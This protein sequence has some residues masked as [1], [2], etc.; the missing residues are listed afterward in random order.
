MTS[1]V[2]TAITFAP[3][4]GFIE[5]SRKLRDLYGSSFILS[6]LSQA[7][8]EDAITHGHEVISPALISVTQGTPNQIVICGDFSEVS[9]RTALARAWQA[10]VDVCRIE[11]ERRL[12]ESKLPGHYTWRRAWDAWGNHT[13]E[14][15]WAQGGSISEVRDR[16]NQTKRARR[17]VGINWQG[18][19]STLSGIDAVAWYGM[20]E[21]MHP[22]TSAAEIQRQVSDYCQRLSKALPDSILDATEQLSVPELIKRVLLVKDEGFPAR[23]KA[24]LE[25]QR[26]PAIEPPA[27]FTEVN[28][29]EANRWTA[30]FQGDGDR[31]GQFL[32]SSGGE[33]PVRLNAF[34][35]AMREWGKTFQTGFDQTQ[36]RIIYA[37]G[38]DFLG[39]LY[40]NPP[41]PELS[42]TEVLDYFRTFPSVWERHNQRDADG[43]LLTVSVGLV[44]AAPGVPQRDV[45]QHCREAE[46]AAKQ[47]G[48]DRLCIRVVFNGGNYLEWACP[49]WLLEAGL[50]E[51][52]RDRRGATKT[53]ASWDHL[54]ADVAALEARHGFSG[55]TNVALGLFEIYF[56]PSL[57]ALVEA[58][59]WTVGTQPGI[60]GDKEIDP[61]PTQNRL[62]QWVVNLAKV[63]YHL[64]RQPR[65]AARP[66]AA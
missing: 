39:I 49:W 46:Q 41:E 51:A 33:D 60:L 48:R 42:G 38:D 7:L 43:N 30:W 53:A 6:F 24:T 26:L 1:P 8:C 20:A 25:Q 40:R 61:T 44:W 31:I 65:D 64:H 52:Y 36:G 22:H 34:S 23:L 12:P 11:I 14:C 54:F 55:G 29:F 58:H 35:R 32:K 10:V 21:K 63:G 66:I 59:L 28:R 18:E 16:L 5:K 9:A 15:F 4:Q 37:G 56:G 57:R 19:S 27:R 3:V 47:G 45:L 13:W 62:N 2:Y 50:M 17:W